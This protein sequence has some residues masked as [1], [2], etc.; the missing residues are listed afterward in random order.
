[1][2]VAHLWNDSKL[3]AQVGQSDGADV[4]AV[5]LNATASKLHD[6]EEKQRQSVMH[7]ADQ[8]TR[9]SAVAIDQCGEAVVRGLARACASNNTN[10]LSASNCARDTVQHKRQTRAVA[11]LHIAGGMIS[12]DDQTHRQARQSSHTETWVILIAPHEGQEGAGLVFS[13]V[14]GASDGVE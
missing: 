14:A 9:V 10:A 6:A 11:R 3:G 12:Y 13:I 1:M 7:I 4:N 2:D 8:H 5:D